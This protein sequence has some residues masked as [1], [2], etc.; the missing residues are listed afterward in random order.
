MTST[1]TAT[2]EEIW[3]L[4]RENA[5]GMKELRKEQ[6]KTEKA[7]REGE[8]SLRE[9]LREAHQR[10]EEARRKGEQ[11][12]REAL[13][14]LSISLDKANGNFNNKWGQFMENL[15]KGDFIRLLRTKKMDVLRV[16][17]RVPYNRTDGT[18]GGD[19]DLLAVNG[20]DIIPTEVKTTL[21]VKNVD[22][23]IETLEKF[24]NYFPEY[25]HKTVYGAVACLND[26]ENAMKY[27][28]S[29]GLLVIKSPGGESGVSIIVNAKDFKPK[30]F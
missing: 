27:A 16:L 1:K 4:I 13:R 10:T 26:N 20:N 19:I 30:E 8:Q 28:E 2:A 11:A 24:K 21:T 22:E 17:S 29:L 23:F 7:R 25:R 12:L 15:V 3:A 5:E 18:I 9:S 14:E 6:R